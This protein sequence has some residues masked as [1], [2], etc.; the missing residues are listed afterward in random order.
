MLWAI[1]TVWLHFCRPLVLLAWCAD[2]AINYDI[3][4]IIFNIIAREFTTIAELLNFFGDTMYLGWFNYQ[5]IIFVHLSTLHNPR[6]FMLM[7]ECSRFK[8]GMTRIFLN[9]PR[10][11]KHLSTMNWRRRNGNSLENTFFTRPWPHS[12]SRAFLFQVTAM[13]IGS[14]Y[15]LWVEKSERRVILLSSFLQ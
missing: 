8:W 10:L 1:G 3:C 15:R 5:F 7:I 4:E 11:I 2:G 14:V 13:C 9:D 12:L 6:L